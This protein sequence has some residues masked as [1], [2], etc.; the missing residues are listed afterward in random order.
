MA[1]QGEENLFIIEFKKMVKKFPPLYFQFF[2]KK[3]WRVLVLYE[4]ETSEPLLLRLDTF[5]KWPGPFTND[6]E[7]TIWLLARVQNA[8]L[9]SPQKEK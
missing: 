6:S 3:Y 1:P 7:Q 9:L 5:A 8:T 2:T 4:I